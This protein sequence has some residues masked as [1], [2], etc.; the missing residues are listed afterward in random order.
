MTDDQSIAL[1]R[2]VR[3]RPN[4]NVN[5]VRE[6]FDLPAGYMLMTFVVAGFT[7]G[8]AP[9]DSVSSGT[10]P[11]RTTSALAPCP[12]VLSPGAWG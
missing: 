5:I 9:D 11:R 2:L 6:P 7:C 1:G 4:S 8:I 3:G 12:R 10:S